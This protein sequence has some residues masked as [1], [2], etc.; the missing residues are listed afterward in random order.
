M[1][2][3]SAGYARPLAAIF[4]LISCVLQVLW[5]K[6]IYNNQREKLI[7]ALGKKITEASRSGIVH[8]L[9]VK[10]PSLGS[11]YQRFF[12]SPEWGQLRMAFDGMNV[13]GLIKGS[14]YEFSAD[15]LKIDLHLTVLSLAKI[16]PVNGLSHNNKRQVSR[17]AEDENADL[18]YLQKLVANAAKQLYIAGKISFEIEDYIP[19]KPLQSK[20][21]GV[22]DHDYETQPLSYDFQHL[23]KVR[24]FFSSLQSGI[25]YAMRF[26]LLS[27]ISIFLI[28]LLTLYLLLS[29]LRSQKLYADARLGFTANMTHELKTPLAIV[30]LALESISKYDLIN[31]PDKLEEYL[32]IGRNELKRLDDMIEK[33]LDLGKDDIIVPPLK[34]SS[35]D[36]NEILKQVVSTMKFV[37][38]GITGANIDLELTSSPCLVSGDFVHLSNVFYNLLENAIKFSGYN[39]QIH[40]SSKHVGNQVQIVFVDNGPGIDSLFHHT[41]FERFFRAP[42]VESQTVKG[43]GLGLYYVKQIVQAHSGHIELKSARGKGANFTISL[44]RLD[45]K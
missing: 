41:I 30:S 15:S 17:L 33:V 11:T 2:W 32:V 14:N 36:V 10:E 13:K 40:V 42:T 1:R 34:P 20:T 4:L 28:T 6:D 39:V 26:Y 16:A 37:Q 25:F 21:F 19:G 22:V 18:T 8:S 24:F 43:S 9:T 3:I 12:M 31:Q 5:L 23:K 38:E 29:L 44:P 27:A 35:L 45:E 7:E